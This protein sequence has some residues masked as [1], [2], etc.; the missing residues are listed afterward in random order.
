M[1]ADCAKNRGMTKAVYYIY[2]TSSI[3]IVVTML[4]LQLL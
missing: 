4:V 3:I 2:I 1:E